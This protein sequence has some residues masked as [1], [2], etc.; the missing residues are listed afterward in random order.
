VQQHERGFVEPLHVI[1]EHGH[2][3]FVREHAQQARDRVVEAVRVV[4][5]RRRVAQ[6]RQEGRQRG[7][8][9]PVQLGQRR[10]A[11]G[12]DPHAV[13][14]AALDLEASPGD[15]DPAAS[16]HMPVGFLEEAGLADARLADEEQQPTRGVG[17]AVEERLDG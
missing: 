15:D 3:H 13:G 11:Q 10:A 9:A 2:R 1:D 6:F 16:F 4:E 7:P 17:G 12:V 8:Q 14:P 5:L